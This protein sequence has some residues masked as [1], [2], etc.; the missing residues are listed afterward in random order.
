[1][2]WHVFDVFSSKASLFRWILFL[3]FHRKSEIAAF[4]AQCEVFAVG[5][6]EQTSLLEVE[7][8]LAVHEA[9]LHLHSHDLSKEHGM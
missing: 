2:E 3:L 5:I 9:F 4:S 8:A 1:M 7:L 6:G